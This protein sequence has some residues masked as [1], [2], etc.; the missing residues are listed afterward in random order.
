MMDERIT[1]LLRGEH[2]LLDLGC[3]DGWFLDGIGERYR[4][5]I[6]IDIQLTCSPNGSVTRSW[7]HVVGDLDAGIPVASSSA[8]VVHAN[9]VIEHLKNPL[10]FLTEA[11][12]VLRPGGC[13]IVTTPNIRYLRHLWLLVVRGRGP[14]TS[15]RAMRT[16]TEWDDGHIHFFTP[17]D[18]AW[19]AQQ[20]GFSTVRTAA[21]IDRS[22]PLRA[23]RA[24]LD[25]MSS[26]RPVKSFLSGNTMLVGYK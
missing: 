10:A 4:L 7:R 5:A 22:G 2:C 26:A 3:G 12:R 16:L 20:A 8:D 13:L 18:L 25:R 1:S 23:L 11:H 24:A 17:S 19:V 14:I 15:A 21:L 6:G 9:Q